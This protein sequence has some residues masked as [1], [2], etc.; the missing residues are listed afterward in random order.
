[1]PL[2]RYAI[3]IDELCHQTD[4][5]EGFFATAP[6]QQSKD[7][8]EH[9]LGYVNF[10]V[11][12]LQCDLPDYTSP[13]G[14][15]VQKT[16]FSTQPLDRNSRRQPMT[17]IT[18]CLWFDGNAEEAARFYSSLFPDSRIDK[19]TRAPSDYPSGKAGDV[20]MVEFTLMGRPFLGLNGGPNVTFNEAVSFQIPVD[21]QAE[22]DRLSEALSAV[23]QAEQ[24]GW[25]KD[26]FGLSWQIVPVQLMRILTAGNPVRARRAFDAMMEM[27][28]IDIAALECA[29]G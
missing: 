23:P 21:T 28:R 14:T 11:E 7:T 8:L 17:T 18:P 10:R 24:C 29:V 22:V 15:L 1:M 12:I 19:V 27:K 2:I 3:K 4:M 6:Y 5:T 25:V 13:L 16:A 9:L 20:L 26:R